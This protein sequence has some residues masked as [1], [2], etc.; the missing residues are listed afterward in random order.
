[1]SGLRFPWGDTIAHSNANYYSSSSLAYDISPTP[2]FHPGYSNS[3]APVNSGTDNGYGLYAMAG[4]VMEWCQDESGGSRILAGSSFMGFANEARC[5]YT[6]QLAPSSA[7]V[8]IGFRTVQR[9]SSSAEAQTDSAVAVDTRDYLLTVSSAHGSPVP[10]VGTN[11]YSWR[12]AVTCSVES[13]VI[14]GL[15]NWT[16]AGWSGSGAVPASG[17]AT[18]TSGFVLTNPVSSIVWNWDTNYWVEAVTNGLGQVTGGNSWA[19]KDSEVTLSMTPDS[20]WLFMGW[21]GDA[22]G[23]Y[24]EE[25]IIIPMIRP[26]SVTATFSDDADEDGILNVDEV[27]YGTN[28]RNRD[29]DGDGLHDRHELIAGTDPTNAA[30][31]LDIQLNLSSSANELVWYG[32]NGRYYQLEY[33][34]DLNTAWQPK[35]TIVSGADSVILKLD[36]GV[37][38][39]RFYRIRVS[40]SPDNL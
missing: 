31:V 23:D 27:G 10:A 14:S 21:S 20:G 9:A 18:N 40:E 8:N 15:T 6:S 2:G 28:P 36:I 4:N 17:T 5:A 30:S 29:T 3:T 39:E 19:L 33:T 12:A 11:L 7:D 25:S 32:V 37:G 22:S 34:D 26:V 35:G 13:A 24:T 16:S 38:T 1:L